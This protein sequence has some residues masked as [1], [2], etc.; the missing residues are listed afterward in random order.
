MTKIRFVAAALLCTSAGNFSLSAQEGNETDTSYRS[1]ELIPVE[2]RAVRVN[3]KS[4]Y[5]VANV[6]EKEI[7]AQNLGQ[8]IPYILN[9]TPSVVITSDA[10]A[11]IGY[12]GIRIRGTDA[13]R[14]NFTV[15]GIPVNDAESQAAI[16][17]DFPDLLSSTNS[18]QLQRGVGSSTNGAGAFGASINLSNMQQDTKAFA[19][20]NNSFGSFNTWK[21]T[22]RA[23]TGML[24]G[25]FQF[26]VRA[27]KISS[28]GYVQRSSADLKALQFISGWTSKDERTAVRFNLF[29]GT[30][31]TGQ[32]W[33]GVHQDS[34]KTNRR[35]NSLGL[36]ADGSYYN[37]QTDNYQQDYYQLF[38]DHKLNKYWSAHAGLFLTR[39]KGFYNE[40][41]LEEQLADYYLPAFTTPAGDT[42]A[43]TN[44]TRRLWLDNYYYGTVYS[45]AYTKGRSQFILGG[46]YTRYDGRHYGYVTW[47]DYGVPDNYKWYN[48]KAFKGD[49]NIYAKWQQQVTKGLYAFGD[50]Q[51]RMVSYDIDGFRKNPDLNPRIRYNFINPKLGLS[52]FITHNNNAES[53]S[54]VSFAVANKE[55][56]RDDFEASPEQLPLNERLYDFEAGYQYRN[57]SWEIGANLYYMRY[58]N[59]LILTGKVN[60]VGAATRT[61][62]PDSYRAGVE[63]TA[64]VKPANWLKINANATLSQ[65]KII[66]FTEYIDNYDAPEQL[67]IQHAETDI[68]LSPSVIAGGVASFEPFAHSSTQQHFFVDLMGKFVGRQYLDNTSDVNRSINAYSLFDLRLRYLLQPGFVQEIGFSLA[69]NNLLNKHYEANGYTFSYQYNGTLT[70]ENYYFPQAGFNFML[71]INIRF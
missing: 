63:L 45:L 65:N 2:V 4:P 7:K 17:V 44:L 58:K 37:D 46:S 51:Y 41:K 31:K 38:L 64:S 66:D 5:A 22:V 30:E 62:T 43:S 34:L 70:T 9:H 20:I 18:I 47:A 13:S 36:K 52:Y 42:F 32:A 33:N 3:D 61:N 6:S 8:D 35:F 29:T 28:D 59:Q 23:G 60:D 15:N 55:P 40:Y 54:Y 1:L 16:F 14:I 49:F 71:G 25:G 39:G 48:L 10:G 24:K 57:P 19:E 11:G 27:S 68:A 50:L 53:K 21:H 26:D 69:L 67:E 12:T 56:N